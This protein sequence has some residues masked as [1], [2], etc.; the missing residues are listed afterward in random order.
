MKTRNKLV[1]SMDNDKV[2]PIVWFLLVI[3]I[4]LSNIVTQA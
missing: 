2:N 3:Y 4:V 1:L